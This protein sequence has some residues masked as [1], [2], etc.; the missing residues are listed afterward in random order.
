MSCLARVLIAL[1]G[2]I[3]IFVAGFGGYAFGD[4][5]G[6]NRGHEIGYE[7]GYEDGCIEGAGSGYTLRDP[8]Y[9]ELMRFLRQDKTDENEYVDGVYTCTNF[10][11]DLDNNAE[12]KGFRAAYVYIEYRDGAHAIV[13][14]ETVDEGLKFIEPQFDDEVMVSEGISFSQAN[15][16]SKPNYDDTITRVVIVW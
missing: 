8:T 12:A 14:F 16:Y 9:S 15:G 11:A 2:L 13:A 10:A 7:E 4:Y 6:Y 1:I 3:L 5:E